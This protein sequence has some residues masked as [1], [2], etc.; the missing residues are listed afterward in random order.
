MME[1]NKGVN[2]L[3]GRQWDLNSLI[4][5]LLELQDALLESQEKNIM[6]IAQIRDLERQVRDIED[7]R[8]EHDNQAQMLADKTR[9]NKY[10]HQELSRMSS[11]LNVRMQDV[12]ELR[13]TISELQHQIKN[14][15]SERDLLAIMLTEA[16][17]QAKSNSKIEISGNSKDT[18]PNNWPF[19][20]GK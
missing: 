1:A 5:K 2:P 12:D 4:Q 6:L 3:T 8:I 9:E 7:L 15:N 17:A 13:S 14:S 11:L 18:K 20:K 10:L 16:E 19:L